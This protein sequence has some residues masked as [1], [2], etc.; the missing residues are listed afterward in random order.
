M[1]QNKSDRILDD[2]RKFP[3]NRRNFPLDELSKYAG[4]HVAWSAD[5]TR[6]L[7]SGATDELVEDE[8]LRA[9]IDPGTVVFGFVD[10]PDEVWI[11]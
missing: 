3:E 4:Q 7:A 2:L 6:I 11:G 1:L 9:G 10:P 5:G 8:L